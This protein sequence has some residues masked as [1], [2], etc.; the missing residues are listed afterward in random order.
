MS[1]KEI[2]RTSLTE[3]NSLEQ[4]IQTLKT[5]KKEVEKDKVTE[6]IIKEAKRNKL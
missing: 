3:I 4:E 1:L 5:K 6:K 2:K